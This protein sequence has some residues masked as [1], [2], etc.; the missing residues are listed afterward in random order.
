MNKTAKYKKNKDIKIINSERHLE[1][2]YDENDEGERL[3]G[4]VHNPETEILIDENNLQ[5]MAK[6]KILKRK[7][8]KRH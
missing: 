5:P 4:E 2:E 6:K 1:Q 8:L 3:G 7:K